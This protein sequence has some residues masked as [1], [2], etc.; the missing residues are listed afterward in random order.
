MRLQGL[1]RWAG[2]GLAACSALLPFTGLISPGGTA[3][4]VADADETHGVTDRRIGVRQSRIQVG[5]QILL[6]ILPGGAVAAGDAKGP[7]PVPRRGFPEEGAGGKGHLLFRGAHHHIVFKSAAPQD[8]RQR[9]RVAEAVDMV[10]RLH[11]HSELLPEVAAAELMVLGEGVFAGQVAVR[12]DVPASDDPPASRCDVTPDPFEESGIAFFDVLVEPHLSAGDDQPGILVEQIAGG[13]GCSK[14][15]IQPLGAPPEPDRIKVGVQN[16]MN[17]HGPG[18]PHQFRA[19]SLLRRPSP[20]IGG[21]R[22]PGSA[23]SCRKW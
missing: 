16:K 14:Y 21:C 5:A 12:L 19:Y 10:C 15:F 2:R 23:P 20:G 1:L 22:Q 18:N 11:P 17:V 8:V 9:S 6:R 7:N 13:S 4:V 3:A